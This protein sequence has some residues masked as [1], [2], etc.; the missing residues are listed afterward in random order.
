MYL[1]KSSNFLNKTTHKETL[2]KNDNEKNGTCGENV[3]FTMI[4]TSLSIYGIGQMTNYT[5]TTAP[6]EDQ[7]AHRITS[8][9]ISDGVTSIGDYAFYE[10]NDLSSVSIPETVTYIGRRVFCECYNLEL[11]KIPE[12]VSSFGTSVFRFCD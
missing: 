5:I 8:V 7:Q 11:I 10:F 12:V 2:I 1:T 4:N 9:I 6:W 3:N